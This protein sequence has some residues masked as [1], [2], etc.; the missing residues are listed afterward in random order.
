[1]SSKAKPSTTTPEETARLLAPSPPYQH[2]QPGSN[3]SHPLQHAP[4]H[5]PDDDDDGNEPISRPSGLPLLP[6]LRFV[7]GL[8]AVGAFVLL[9]VGIKHDRRR[10]RWQYNNGYAPAAVFVMISLLWQCLCVFHNFRLIVV[11]G[12]KHFNLCGG[13]GGRRKHCRKGGNYNI[14]RG[15]PDGDNDGKNHWKSRR[16]L[17]LGVVDLAV[18]V[19]LL[20]CWIVILSNR[21]GDAAAGL[22]GTVLF[23]EAFLVVFQIVPFLRRLIITTKEEYH[24]PISLPIAQAQMG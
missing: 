20:P 3:Q 15:H 18:F 7:T 10:H 12:K 1:M 9:V 8:L 13:C 16:N 11:L 19:A 5:N 22:T 4:Y 17:G 24:Y 14:L 21:H 6:T 2:Q 23:F